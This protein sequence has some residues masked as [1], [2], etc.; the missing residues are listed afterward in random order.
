MVA[1]GPCQEI[2]IKENIRLH[3][4]EDKVR[5]VKADIF[6]EEKN[7]DVIVLNPPY[8]NREARDV[9][10]QSMWDKDHQSVRRFFR[11]ARGYLA[12]QGRIYCTWANFAD[13]SFIEDLVE[14]N[15]FVCCSIAETMKDKKAYRVYEIKER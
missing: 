8:T 2:V 3:G 10:E 14:R 12:A 4:L 11:E 9:V 15:N 5:T 13:F 6:P 7:F 1:S